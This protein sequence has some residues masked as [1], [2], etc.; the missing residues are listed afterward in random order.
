MSADLLGLI[1]ASGWAAGI[2]LYAVAAL[3]GVF[4]RLGLVDSPE[5]L[6][7]TE[8]IVAAVVLYLV[9]FVVDKVPYLDNVWDAVHTVV[10]PVGAAVLGFTVAGEAGSEAEGVGAA[11]AGLLA[12]SSHA[13]KATTRAAVNVSPEPFTNVGLSLL[14]DGVVAGLITLAAAYPLVALVVVAILVAAAGVLT[15]KLWKA[16]R[17]A[18][19]A[20]R[21]RYAGYARRPR[22]DAPET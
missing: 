2:N 14:E 9:E 19:R 11:V 17:R 21:R 12:L 20:A 13:A 6:T 5:F 10:R 7:R 8:V 18:W 1:G 15:V 3:L 4:G 22:P 16:A